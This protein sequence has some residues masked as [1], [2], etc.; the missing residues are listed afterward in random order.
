MASRPPGGGPGKTGGSA[1]LRRRGA[2]GASRPPHA[3]LSRAVNT[4]RSDGAGPAARARALRVGGTRASTPTGAFAARAA[5]RPALT[6]CFEGH[7]IP[8]PM[9]LHVLYHG[10]C[11]D[12]CAS[13]ALLRTFSPANAWAW[14]RT[15]SATGRCS[16]SRA[17]PSR[18]TRFQADWC[19][20]RFPLLAHRLHWWFDHH[21]SAFPTPADREAYERDTSGQKF[22]DP[23]APSCTGFM[24][25]ILG[26]RFGLARRR[27]RRPGALGRRHR[28]GPVRLAPHARWSSTSR[29]SAIMTLIEAT[30]DPAL[31]PRLIEA[32]QHEPLCRIAAQPWISGPLGPILEKH[33]TAIEL[34][35]AARPGTGRGGRRSTWPT[36]AIEAA[37]KF[38]AYEL[39]PEAATRWWCRATRSAT[40][41]SVGS[42]PWA[43]APPR[44]RHRAASAS[45]TVAADTPWWA[46]SPCPG[47]LPEARRIA[48]E[49]ASTL[50]AGARHDPRRVHPG[51]GRRRRLPRG[52]L[53][54]C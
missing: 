11:F 53:A 19:L 37:N 27:P 7:Y 6:L 14:R 45:A 1:G 10:N 2:P 29:P 16:T 38:V 49:I 18:P 5:R 9:P 28:L 44:A 39:F 40:K 51:G 21:A 34:V 46:R 52:P 3:S 32:M 50:R 26:E 24:A 12:G 17:T 4:R 33:R 30:K 15:P 47:T 8:A 43:R 13:A 25:R 20:R 23:A 31:P 36:T 35:R 41:V 48:A 22:W 54:R 42:N